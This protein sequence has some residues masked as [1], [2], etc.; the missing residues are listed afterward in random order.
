MIYDKNLQLIKIKLT[1]INS[2]I[3]FL[4][5]EKHSATV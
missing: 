1:F 2:K 4:T 5:D 3:K